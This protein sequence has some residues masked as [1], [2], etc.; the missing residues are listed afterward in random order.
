MPDGGLV[1]IERAGGSLTVVGV[2]PSLN[3]WG[4]V[5]ATV[6]LSTLEVGVVDLLLVETD[7]RAGKTVRSSSDDLRRAGELRHA[8]HRFCQGAA[9]VIAEV[10]SG[11]QSAR[12]AMSNGICLGVLA[13]SPLPIIEV[14]PLE[15]KLATVG[16]KTATKADMIGWAT[17][18]YPAAPWLMSRGRL[19]AKN[20]HLA[21]AVAIV[22]AGIA[23]AALQSSISVLQT[24]V[25]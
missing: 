8:F 23:T 17:N 25:S 3:S 24:L 13:S 14:S 2:D 12:G 4:M 15:T 7:K 11:T 19:I 1:N 10:P 18:L 22:H 21:D 16:R 5:R 20:E 9:I 6:N